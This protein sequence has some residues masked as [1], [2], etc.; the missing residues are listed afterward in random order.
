MADEQPLSWLFELYDSMSGP[1]EAMTSA[2]G[3]VD[4]ALQNAEKSSTAAQGAFDKTGKAG[5]SLAEFFSGF[6]NTNYDKFVADSGK[7]TKES[8]GEI[9]AGIGGIDLD[10][11]GRAFGGGGLEGVFTL[12]IGEAVH[13]AIDE[14]KLFWETIEKGVEMAYDLGKEMVGVA[15]GAEKANLSFH[16]LL[17][18]EGGK[19]VL[20]WVEKIQRTSAYAGPQIKSMMSELLTAG[21][22]IEDAKDAFSAAEDIAAVLKGGDVGAAQGAVEA[23]KRIKLKGTA[24]ARSLM[25]LG[26]SPDAVAQNVVD[27][28]GGSLEATKKKMEA[29]K[30]N[31]DVLMQAVYKGIEN[32]TGGALGTGGVAA[33][34]TVDA[35][36]AKVKQLPERYFEALSNGPGFGQFQGFLRKIVDALDPSSEMGQ[37]IQSK[38]AEIFDDIFTFLFGDES[39][40][41]GLDKLT[42]GFHRVLEIVDEVW[43]AV[44]AFGHALKVAYDIAAGFVNF[45]ARSGHFM[46]ASLELVGAL[47][48]DKTGRFDVKAAAAASAHL[49]GELSEDDKWSIMAKQMKRHGKSAGDGYAAGLGDSTATVATA[50]ADVAMSSVDSLQSSIDAHSPSRVF[51]KFGRWA[52]MGYAEG[53]ASTSTMID[54]A[55]D[56][57][58]DPDSTGAADVFVP[59][60]TGAGGGGIYIHMPIQVDVHGGGSDELGR[61]VAAKISERVPGD[62]ESA[63]AHLATQQG[64][65]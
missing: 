23:L 25:R 53:L 43:P 15:A 44:L 45:L 47:A 8:L 26:L 57:A 31:G 2:L 65:G 59:T 6:G 42:D 41:S 38:I 18:D 61:D 34:N 16:L 24:D 46:T 32:K 12:G 55:A 9:R 48:P 33:G 11:L 51:A 50:A 64:V 20:E 1:S 35:L 52:G 49:H 5:K 19:D 7:A 14:I 27:M 56:R 22:N 60:S 21:F 62:L 63:L 37:Q 28:L 29:G 40:P 4:K 39:G 30:I 36:L 58:F 54:R 17:G 13:F 3:D 10:K